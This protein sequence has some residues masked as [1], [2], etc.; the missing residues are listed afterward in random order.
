MYIFIYMNIYTH[1]DNTHCLCVCVRLKR[2]AV[3][4]SLHKQANGFNQNDLYQR[5]IYIFQSEILRAVGHSEAAI[6]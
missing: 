3:E 6:C 5:D 4:K 2:N 1:T